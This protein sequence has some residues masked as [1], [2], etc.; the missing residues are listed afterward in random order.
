MTKPGCKCFDEITYKD[1]DIFILKVTLPYKVGIISR[2]GYVT[3]I[4]HYVK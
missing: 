3:G 4:L 2:S 1:R